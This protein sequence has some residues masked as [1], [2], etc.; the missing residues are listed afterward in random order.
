M[1][2]YTPV[3]VEKNLSSTI[4]PSAGIECTPLPCR[5]NAL[6]TEAPVTLHRIAL[7]RNDFCIRLGCCLHYASVIQ[8]VLGVKITLPNPYVPYRGKNHIHCKFKT[9]DI[10]HDRL[11]SDLGKNEIFCNS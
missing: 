2:K 3:T 6:T 1:L 11:I 5:R 7:E 9:M 4:G 10:L 8:Y